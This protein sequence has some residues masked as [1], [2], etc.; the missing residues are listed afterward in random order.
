MKKMDF[1]QREMEVQVRNEETEFL[2]IK[3]GISAGKRPMWCQEDIQSDG[4][5]M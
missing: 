2:M 5:K 3:C 4:E 1:P